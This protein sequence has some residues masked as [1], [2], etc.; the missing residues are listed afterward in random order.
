MSQIKIQFYKTRIGDLILGSFEEKLC[1][2]DFRYRKM[3][4]AVDSRIKNGLNAEFVENDS[5]VIQQAKKQLDEYLGGD[6]KKF[7]LPLLIVG[8]EFQKSVWQSLMKVPYGITSTYL[9][10]AKNIGNERAVRAVASANGANALSL[11]IPCHRI[12]GSDGQL[13]GY[14]GGLSVKKRLLN[15]EKR[16]S[17]SEELGNV[18]H[19]NNSQPTKKSFAFSVS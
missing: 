4:K 6:R 14:G 15:L 8:T 18:T 11:I 3:R 2:L 10:L 13:V 16:N 5:E 19:N 7:S 17:S 9:Q 12:I 1:L